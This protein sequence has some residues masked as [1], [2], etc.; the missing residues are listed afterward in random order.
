VT[1]ALLE[2]F[3]FLLVEPG[4][5]F[6]DRFGER[7]CFPDAVLRFNDRTVV[8]EV[9]SRGTQ[10]GDAWWQLERYYRP[11]V[12]ATFPSDPVFTVAVV[13]RIDP[14]AFSAFTVRP[15]EATDLGAPLPAPFSVMEWSSQV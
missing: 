12:E 6:R 3:P 11:V 4:F 2:R 1:A 10:V 7:T 9:K 13:R 5:R 15:A 14:M 8:V